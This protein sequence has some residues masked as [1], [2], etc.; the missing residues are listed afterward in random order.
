MHYLLS[1]KISLRGSALK[2]VG[3]AASPGLRKQNEMAAQYGLFVSEQTPP[4][5]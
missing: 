2:L 5:L 3:Y 4:T 1:H